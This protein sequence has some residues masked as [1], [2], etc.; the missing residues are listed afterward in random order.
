MNIARFH[1]LW[2]AVVFIHCAQIDKENTAGTTNANNGI[3]TP[4]PSAL[5]N[6]QV[7][8]HVTAAPC[9]GITTNG[10]FAGFNDPA[11]ATNGV[12]G[13]GYAAGSVDVFSLTEAGIYATLVLDW[14]GQTVKNIPGADLIV[15]ENPFEVVG[16]Y[17]QYFM[18]LIVVTV[19]ADNTNYCGWAT[20][21][22]GAK[23]SDSL[24]D[25]QNAGLTGDATQYSA[26]PEQWQNF[27]GKTPVV[28]SLDNNPLG[29]DTVFA[30][31]TRQYFNGATPMYSRTVLQGGGDAFDL[32]NL[33]TD[34]ATCSASVQ[35]NLKTN[36]IKY[37]MLTAAH[38][39][40]NP[41]TGAIY[42]HSAASNGPDIDGVLARH[43]VP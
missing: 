7:A 26:W 25:F 20:N 16:S 41:A 6:S 38:S 43:V 42:P 33:V 40:V 17:G 14:N 30:T 32:D 10:C 8:A 13:G 28:W 37:V 15:Y 5:Y 11:K 2:V 4:L 21:Y 39:L 24:A 23:G 27:A 35:N 34:A 1:L 18:D 3:G 36:G 12:R 9:A 22:L 29:Y 19:S 31:M